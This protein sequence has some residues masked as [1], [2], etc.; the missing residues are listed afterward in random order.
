MKRAKPIITTIGKGKPAVAV[1]AAM[2][3]NES[4]AVIIKKLK[5]NIVLQK[6]RVDFIVAN[7]QALEKKVRYI[8]ADLNRVFPGHRNGNSEEQLAYQLVKIGFF[9]DVVL[10]LHTCSME[11]EPFCIIRSENGKQIELAGKTGLSNI[12]IYPKEIQKG[13]SFID[14]VSCGIGL[15]LGLH[16]KKETTVSGYNAVIQILQSLGMVGRSLEKV[17][18]KNPR[19]FRVESH[20]SHSKAFNPSNKIRNFTLIKK[21]EILGS[22]KRSVRKAKYEFYPIMYRQKSY[23]NILCW[24]AQRIK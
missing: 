24:V 19:I 15:E 21:D 7:P 13:E 18:Y 4:S 11:S 8:D 14:Y 16:G 20:L 5:K 12:V 9:Y 17:E 2:H 10:D 22:N 23:G 3:G 6:G 1:V